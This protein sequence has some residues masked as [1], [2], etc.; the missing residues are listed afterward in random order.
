MLTVGLAFSE[1]VGTIQSE[2][3][4]FQ[5]IILNLKKSQIFT[6]IFHQILR[7]WRHINPGYSFASSIRF[8]VWCSFEPH[9]ICFCPA[10]PEIEFKD[11]ML[12][13]KF[14]G[15]ESAAATVIIVYSCN[16]MY[17]GGLCRPSWRHLQDWYT[18]GKPLHILPYQGFAFSQS[19]PCR[20][21]SHT[22]LETTI[23]ASCCR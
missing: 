17:S 19:Q 15:S 22:N 21:T 13:S 4:I 12:P 18:L 23:S 2:N 3:F 20:R 16:S 10:F 1:T 8:P 9:M 7:S 14:H 5:I 11:R 6:L